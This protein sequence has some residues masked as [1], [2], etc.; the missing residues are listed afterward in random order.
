MGCPAIEVGT[1]FKTWQGNYNYGNY[2]SK[3]KFKKMF[4]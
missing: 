1:V 4:T 3:F 2:Q